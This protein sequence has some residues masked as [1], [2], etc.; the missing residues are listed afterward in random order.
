MA[1]GIDQV[2]AELVRAG[3]DTLLQRLLSLLKLIWHTE[4][5][6]SAWKKAIIVPILKKGGSQE[7][8]NYRGISLLSV[9]SKVFMKIIQSRL[10]EHHGQTSREE[11]TGFRPHRGCVDQMFTIRQL[12]EETIRCG[13]R[14]TIVF[15]DFKSAF[16]CIHW[17]TLWKALET[18]HIPDKIIRLL[19]ATYHGSTS[20][21]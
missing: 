11:Q 12:M 9:I 21:V 20:V 19:K 7:C 6:P 17:P 5:I 18:E 14:T 1:P 4:R 13:K 16:D 15:I 10:Q 2:S 3:G 8:K